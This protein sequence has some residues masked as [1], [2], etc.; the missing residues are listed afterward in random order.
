MFAFVVPA[1]GDRSGDGSQPAIIW[2]VVL[3]PFVALRLK[4]GGERRG[5]HKA[6]NDGV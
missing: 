4:V 2:L 1:A 5:S 6:A 3:L